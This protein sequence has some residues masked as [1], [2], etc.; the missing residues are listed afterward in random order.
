VR[1]TTAELTAS[2]NHADADG[3][4]AAIGPMRSR[5]AFIAKSGRR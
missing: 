5:T 3:Q 1:H 2:I 4:S